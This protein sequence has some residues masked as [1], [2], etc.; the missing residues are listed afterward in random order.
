MITI[1]I[2]FLGLGFL[3]V[4]LT[5]EVGHLLVARWYGV[6]VVSVSIGFGPPLVEHIDRFGTC[7]KLATVPFRGSCRYFDS[8]DVKK[9]E[10]P[11]P[12]RYA[13]TFSEQSVSQKA[14]I[15]AAGPL[16]NI[17]FAVGVY[18]AVHLYS[19]QGDRSSIDLNDPIGPVSLIA[20][21]SMFIGLFNLVPLP[22]LD[23]GRILF[24][25]I[26]FIRGVP[27]DRS[28]QH[29]L[30][31]VGGLVLKIATCSAIIAVFFHLWWLPGS[32]PGFITTN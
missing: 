17:A 21:L 32:E 2:C 23:G 19:G 24:F 14:A 1:V 4:L 5:H 26:E 22:P 3:A 12:S 28:E 10:I 7:W 25:A 9:E 6:H 15:C 20:G 31:A 16:F 29:R 8:E 30:T 11:I 27:I 13:E 18:L